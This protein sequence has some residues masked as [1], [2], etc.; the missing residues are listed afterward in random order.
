MANLDV[1]IN[2]TEGFDSTQAIS[3]IYQR[4][5]DFLKRRLGEN[6]PG[7][8]TIM[9]NGHGF[10]IKNARGSNLPFVIAATELLQETSITTLSLED[11]IKIIAHGQAN[12]TNH[13]EGIYSD[14]K[15]AI[16]YTNDKS[17]YQLT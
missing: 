2:P 15:E 4:V 16:L 14:I 17:Q 8:K 12:D 7:Y 5:S 11:T 3:S 13:F 1:H 9:H 6:S 10:N